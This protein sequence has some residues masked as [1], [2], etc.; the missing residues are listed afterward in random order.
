MENKEVVEA[1]K[2]EGAGRLRL[3][4]VDGLQEKVMRVL[5]PEA[6]VESILMKSKGMIFAEADFMV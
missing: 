3:V 6:E 2:G 5:A 1:V 4:L